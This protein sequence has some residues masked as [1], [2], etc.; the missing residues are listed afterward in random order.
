MTTISV[1]TLRRILHER[2][3][4]WQATK[5]W[6]ASNDPD[7]TTKMRRILDLYDHPPG[8]RASAVRGR[9]RTIEPATPTRQTEI[10]IRRPLQDP[11]PGLPV[12]GCM[13]GH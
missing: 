5:T 10:R 2:G 13:T 7:F 4:S 1:E 8:G 9:V 3:V 12:Q 6:K 11:P